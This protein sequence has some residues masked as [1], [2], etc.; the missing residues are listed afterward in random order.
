MWGLGKSSLSQCCTG[1]LY[2]SGMKSRGSS[3]W[4]LKIKKYCFNYH[5]IIIGLVFI[6]QSLPWLII[7][8]LFGHSVGTYCWH[9]PVKDFHCFCLISIQ[10]QWSPSDT[11]VRHIIIYCDSMP[12][13]EMSQRQNTWLWCSYKFPFKRIRSLIWAVKGSGCCAQPALILLSSS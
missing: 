2:N 3:S 8:R 7:N 5:I 6:F 10:G 13:A 12:S 1:N 9:V 11:I 4:P